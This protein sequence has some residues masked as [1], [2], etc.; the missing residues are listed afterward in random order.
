ML[1]FFFLILSFFFKEGKNHVDQTTE[2]L[3]KKVVT[4][5]NTNMVGQLIFIL[6]HISK[7]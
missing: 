7:L 3:K 5:V 1:P 2:N 4:L 6:F